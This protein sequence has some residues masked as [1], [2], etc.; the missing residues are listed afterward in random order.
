VTFCDSTS[1]RPLMSG[2]CQTYGIQ[3]I[4]STVFPSGLSTTITCMDNRPDTPDNATLS[5]FLFNFL[6]LRFVSQKEKK[7]EKKRKL[8]SPFEVACHRRLYSLLVRS[9]QQRAFCPMASPNL[10]G[11]STTRHPHSITRR[12]TKSGRH[13]SQRWTYQGLDLPRR[14]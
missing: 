2:L 12:R 8:C 13:L 11:P 9:S 7:R 5:Q 6:V 4:T 3:V 1:T 14:P 10:P